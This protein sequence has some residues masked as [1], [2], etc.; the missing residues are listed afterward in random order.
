MRSRTVVVFTLQP[1]SS[2]LPLVTL[3]AAGAA[4]IA[5]AVVT[6]RRAKR[7]R[8]TFIALVFIGV[9]TIGLGIGLT[10]S[11]GARSTITVGNGYVYIDS[12]SL[13]G[14]GD[15]NITSNQIQ[16]SYVGV[17]GTGNLTISKQHGT[18]SGD[19][20]VGVFTLGGGA[21]AYVVSD[22][23]TSLV[24]HLYSGSYVVLGTNDTSALVAAFSH[25]VQYVPGAASGN[26]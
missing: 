25:S 23:S 16:S 19:F 7:V 14:V 8:R 10:Y 2:I 1:P 24:L 17:I 18:N 13:W 9:V 12:P 26:G 21:T 4:L 6:G 3:A 22:N 5:L 15:M 11:I 20:N